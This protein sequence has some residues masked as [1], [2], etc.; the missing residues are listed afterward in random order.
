DE[1]QKPVDRD[2]PSFQSTPLRISTDVT[3]QKDHQNSFSPVSPNGKTSNSHPTKLISVK[4]RQAPIINDIHYYNGTNNN[5]ASP[6][7]RTPAIHT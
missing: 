6:T 7:Q 5:P 1:I 4:V 2:L 3:M